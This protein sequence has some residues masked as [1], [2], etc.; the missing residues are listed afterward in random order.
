MH[1]CRENQVPKVTECKNYEIETLRNVSGVRC[2]KEEGGCNHTKWDLRLFE[3]VL[4]GKFPKMV[5]FCSWP[6]PETA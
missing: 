1:P 4:L 3:V 5:L 6:G 2:K